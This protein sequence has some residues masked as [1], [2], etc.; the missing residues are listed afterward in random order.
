MPS[1]FSVG[2]A[3][4]RTGR[5]AILLWLAGLSSCVRTQEADSPKSTPAAKVQNAVKEADLTTVTLS[6][7]AERRLGISTTPVVVKRVHRSRTFGG[8]VVVPAGRTIVVSAPIAGTLLANSQST[9]PVGGLSVNQGQVLCRL[10]P[11]LSPERD[12]QAQAESGLALAETRFQ[13]AKLRAERAEQLL[14]DRAGSQRA[15]EQAREDLAVAEEAVK[16]ARL[17][18]D[19]IRQA[20]LESDVPM[21]LTAPQAGIM[22]KVHAS[23]GQT[24]SGGMP[25]F[26]IVSL[27]SVWIRVPV[28]VGELTSI[29]QQQG[30]RIH[31]LADTA[32]SVA[33][34]AKAVAAP[35]S[36]DPNT[37]TTDL[38]FE[39]SNPNGNLRPGQRVGV[40]L[41]L[42][43]SEEGLVVPWSAILFDTY[44]G[45]WLYENS[46]PQLFVRR[47]VEVRHVVGSDAVLSRGPAVGT[48]VVATGA[49]ELFGTE[50]GSGK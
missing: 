47:R 13:A 44:G 26:E 19:R 27:N 21:V 28:Y 43:G 46:A 5:L 50:F 16:T 14:R 22:H 31:G 29:E 2:S 32:G 23:P 9:A 12:L 34:M 7:E 25:L 39:L 6:P 49:A 38:F 15:A 3:H 36:A 40:T 35:P 11:L 24:V 33:R 18:L 8:E 30:A 4:R 37:A 45:T 48:K 20:P 17:R 1:N 41:S 10:L 42:R